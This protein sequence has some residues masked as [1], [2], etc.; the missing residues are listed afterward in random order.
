[1]VSGHTLPLSPEEIAM[2]YVAEI[3]GSRQTGFRLGE[4]TAKPNLSDSEFFKKYHAE[5]ATDEMIEARALLQL[6]SCCIGRFLD[7]KGALHLFAI[8]DDEDMP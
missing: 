5:E 1:M 6:G 4:W 3:T 7:E 2:L 8:D